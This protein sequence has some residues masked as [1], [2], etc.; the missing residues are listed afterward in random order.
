MKD[1]DKFIE[2]NGFRKGEIVKVGYNSLKEFINQ[3]VIEE[4]ENAK[5][6]FPS[7]N[8]VHTDSIF[9]KLT[10]ELQQPKTSKTLTAEDFLEECDYIS[11]DGDTVYIDE[12]AIIECMKQYA[13]Y[14][15]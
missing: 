7:V 10:K 8:R 12:E 6:K 4:L 2:E 13:H 15:K 3:R 11:Q 5:S 1:I 14:I 9:D